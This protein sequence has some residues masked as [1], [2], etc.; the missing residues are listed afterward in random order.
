[1][2]EEF[3]GR[4]AVV[5]GAGSGIGQAIAEHLAGLGATVVAVDRDAEAAEA[6]AKELRAAGAEATAVS[7]D[8]SSSS[9]VAAAFDE[10]EQRVG[11]VHYLVN[12]AGVLRMA[13]ATELT[14]EQWRQTFAVNTDGVFYVSR[15]A[16]RR[17]AQRRRG[18]IVTIASNAAR[19]PRVHM[20]AYG[21]S[22]AATASFTKT[23]GLELAEFGVRCNVVEP[24]STDTPMLRGMWTDASGPSRTIDGDPGEFRVAIPLR[25][26]ARPA[27]IADAVAFLLSDRAGHITMHEL[28]VDGGASLGA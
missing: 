27:D 6:T 16:G 20:A 17:M 7:A 19:V 2:S 18:A 4:V 1:M 23:L 26:L 5:T 28:C 21:A 12:A 25:K 15:E 10:I 13:L 22:K 8:V 14:D 3:T 24:G 11:P 9:A